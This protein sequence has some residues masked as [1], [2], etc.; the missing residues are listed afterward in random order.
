[1]WQTM[2][3]REMALHATELTIVHIDVSVSF[4]FIIAQLEVKPGST[5]P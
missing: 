5:Y 2:K 4:V 3:A 1:M